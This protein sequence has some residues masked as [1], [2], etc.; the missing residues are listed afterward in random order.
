MCAGKGGV[1][2][3]GNRARATGWTSTLEGCA[4]LHREIEGRGYGSLPEG[5]AAFSAVGASLLSLD[6]TVPRSPGA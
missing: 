1:K 4:R 6:V 5:W 3:D 2:P